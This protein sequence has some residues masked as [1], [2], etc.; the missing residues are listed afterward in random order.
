MGTHDILMLTHIRKRMVKFMTKKRG[1]SRCDDSK[2]AI[3][4]L[5]INP[6]EKKELVERLNL[7]DLDLSQYIR[8]LI[9]L[10]KREGYICK[11]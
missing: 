3:I 7:S 6:D 11:Y 9:E 8:L 4:K 1:R 10:D 5:R 2:T